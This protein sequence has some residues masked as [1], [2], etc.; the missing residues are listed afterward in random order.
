MGSDTDAPVFLYIAA[1]ADPDAAQGDWDAIKELAKEKTITVDGLVLVSRAP[2]GR[3][4]SRTTPTPS[5]VGRHAALA[6]ACS[7]V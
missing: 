5:V 4:T 7:S 3:S 2:T 6:A 1:Y